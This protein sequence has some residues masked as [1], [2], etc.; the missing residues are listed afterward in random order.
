MKAGRGSEEGENV[1][2]EEGK[3]EEASIALPSEVATSLPSSSRALLRVFVSVETSW[4][5][6]RGLLRGICRYSSLHKRWRIDLSADAGFPR[7]ADGAI[8]PDHRGSPALLKRGIPIVFVSSLHKAIRRSHRIVPDDQAIGR[9]A[10]AHLLERGLR[11]FAFVGYDG[12]YWSR[13]RQASF[14]QALVA[15]GRVCTVFEQ[16]RDLRLRVWR[17]EQKVLAEWLK[18]LAR[19]VGLMACN[20]DRARQV[21]DACAMA[22]LAIPE[23][24][25]LLGVD[26]D[27]LVCNFSNP[28][29]S[30]ISLGLEDAGYQAAMLLDG[31]MAAKKGLESCIPG[32]ILV[33]PIVVVSRQS[34]DVTAIDDPC[35][36]RALQF[37]RENSGRTIE[38]DDVVHRVAIS[39]RSLFDRFRRA[40]GC[41]V[42]QCIKRTRAARIE[43]L[44]LG[45]SHSIDE[46]AK[47]LGFTGPDHIALYFRSVKGMNP[48]AFRARYAQRR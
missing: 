10:A 39:R 4:E 27:E 8:M 5:Y 24:V 9:M 18:T 11:H 34:T 46:I 44:L 47:T 33:S 25:A 2:R 16:S 35:V 37:I 17:K 12:M 26:N 23:E 41:T 45:T 42:H 3:N 48:N 32:Q 30:S 38:V 31:L 21:V 15:S 14:S 43:E 7:D 6:E 13:Q 19:P 40:V 20:D 29:I 36:M 22:G 28:S 1:R